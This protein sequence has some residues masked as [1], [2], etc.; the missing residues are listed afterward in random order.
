MRRCTRRPREE[1]H[2]SC[3]WMAKAKGLS[4]VTVQRIW[5]ARGLKP[6]RVKTFKLST[7]SASRRSSS[8][9]A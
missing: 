9:S 1:T 7:T 4:P 3:R 8:T 5:S 2:W 6:H